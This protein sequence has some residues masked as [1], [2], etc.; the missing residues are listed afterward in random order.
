MPTA[1]ER[2][3]VAFLTAVAVLGGSVRVLQSRALD[4]AVAQAASLSNEGQ[5]SAEDELNRQVTAVEQ[6]K[7]EKKSASKKSGPPSEPID[8]NTAT[9]EQLDALPRVGPALAARIVADRDSLGPFDSLEALQRVKG[10]GPALARGLSPYV[11]FS[12]GLRPLHVDTYRGRP[13]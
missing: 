1:A 5:A 13:P 11:T 2:Q 4:Q 9:A 10:I 12:T 6:A 8:V 7:V 3:A